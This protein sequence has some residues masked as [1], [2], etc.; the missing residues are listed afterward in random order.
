MKNRISKYLEPMDKT[1]IQMAKKTNELLAI[2]DELYSVGQKIEYWQKAKAYLEYY[3]KRV[4]KEQEA[5]Q[6]NLK[7]Q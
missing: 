4:E 2:E 6:R 7:N 3:Y 5:L 1:L